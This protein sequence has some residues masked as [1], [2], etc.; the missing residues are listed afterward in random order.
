[1]SFCHYYIMISGTVLLTQFHFAIYSLNNTI[2][3]NCKATE[4]SLR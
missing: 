4:L 3:D 1:M 2:T